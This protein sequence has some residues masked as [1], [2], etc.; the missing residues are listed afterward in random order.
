MGKHERGWVEATE[1]LTARL[2]NGAEPDSD[3]EARGR[4]D[5]TEALAGPP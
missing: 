3:L 4:P 5:L 1:K 2:A